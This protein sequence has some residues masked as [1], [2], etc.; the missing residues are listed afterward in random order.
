MNVINLKFMENNM[1]NEIEPHTTHR[2]S[3]SI[4]DDFRVSSTFFF[5]RHSIYEILCSRLLLDLIKTSIRSISAEKSQI[6]HQTTSSRVGRSEKSSNILLFEVMRAISFTFAVPLD[7]W[8][9]F[10]LRS[11][12][13]TV[14]T[15]KF[16]SL[17]G[18]WFVCSVEILHFTITSMS[19]ICER[20]HEICLLDWKWKVTENFYSLNMTQFCVAATAEM[21]FTAVNRVKFLR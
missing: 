17:M 9:L 20:D 18:G 1:R 12:R 16:K 2:T 5:D 6:Q 10:H 21:T 3:S 4:D 19:A 15:R 13:R 7:L 11:T 8:L 14:N